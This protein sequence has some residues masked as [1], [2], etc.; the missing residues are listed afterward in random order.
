MKQILL[1]VSLITS[2]ELF[3]PDVSDVRT[4]DTFSL[5]HIENDI[6]AEL[7]FH[8]QFV[9]GYSARR[10]ERLQNNQNKICKLLVY[11]KVHNAAVYFYFSPGN[12][13]GGGR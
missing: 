1:S 11:Q 13:R 9:T 2:S 12:K 10:S 6:S 7:F 4:G 5:V 3:N 8:P